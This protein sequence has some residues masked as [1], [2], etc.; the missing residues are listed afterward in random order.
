MHGQAGPPSGRMP[1]PV[2][3]PHS[4]TR[5][6]SQPVCALAGDTKIETPEG[7]MTLKTVAG[8]AIPVFTRD[9]DGRVRFR[10]V[11]NAR[12]VSEQQ[13]VL[14]VTLETGQ[15]FRVGADQVLFKKGMLESRADSLQAG[16]EL[17]PAFHYPDGYEYADDRAGSQVTS[18]AAW[19][20]AKVEA[21]GAADI[22]SLG[23]NKTGCFFLSAGVLCKA[24]SAA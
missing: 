17:V 19:R 9:V 21:A 16:D 18:A 1:L 11:L 14:K 15:S 7:A 10:M 12:K 20:V 8:K 3:G 5:C 13:P 6:M 4:K 24:E 22:Y 2:S 23:V